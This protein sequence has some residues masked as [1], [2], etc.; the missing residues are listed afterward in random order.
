MTSVSLI[1]IAG[2][3]LFLWLVIHGLAA[4]ALLFIIASRFLQSRTPQA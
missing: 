3:L 2:I 4:L 1:A